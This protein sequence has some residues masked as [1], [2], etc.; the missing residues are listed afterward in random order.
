MFGGLL[1]GVRL[2]AGTCAMIAEM[3]SLAQPYGFYIGL[4]IVLVIFGLA[5]ME[6]INLR[7]FRYY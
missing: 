7:R 1:L 6:Y 5:T 3:I 2:F 4:G